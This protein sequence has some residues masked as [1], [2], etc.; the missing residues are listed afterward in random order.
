MPD[1]IV[2]VFMDSKICNPFRVV[3]YVGFV[4]E[5]VTLSYDIDPFR[6][7][8]IINPLHADAVL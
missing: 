3:K 6:G 7:S 8:M 2:T 5:G 1:G 4:S